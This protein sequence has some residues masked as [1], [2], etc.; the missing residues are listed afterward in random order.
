MTD[1]DEANCDEAEASISEGSSTNTS[2]EGPMTTAAS[3]KMRPFIPIKSKPGKKQK[4]DEMINMTSKAINDASENLK[5]DNVGDI[6]AYLERENQRAREHE[7]KLFS[8]LANGHQH[9]QPYHMP[10][11]PQNEPSFSMPNQRNVNERREGNNT[12][13]SL[14]QHN[15]TSLIQN[16]GQSQDDIYQF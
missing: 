15:F 12:S 7:R 16:L 5:R 9:H 11:P 8:M 13:L 3:V 10:F 2:S 1:P 6:L 4:I 14:Q